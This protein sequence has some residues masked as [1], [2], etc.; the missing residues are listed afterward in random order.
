M[1]NSAR[2]GCGVL[3]PVECQNRSCVRDLFL[4]DGGRGRRAFGLL[5]IRMSL[6]TIQK[7]PAAGTPTRD[8]TYVFSSHGWFNR[9]GASQPL[10][11]PV[12]S[13]CLTSLS[14]AE[15]VWCL[16]VAY[17]RQTQPET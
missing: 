12:F 1:Q 17:I 6:T 15:V 3:C 7:K 5:L 14:L 9:L 16:Y 4:R 11:T 2:G 13:R 8:R 10:A